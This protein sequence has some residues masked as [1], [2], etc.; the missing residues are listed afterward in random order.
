MGDLVRR[1]G[2]KYIPH[3]RHNSH[4]SLNSVRSLPYN[5]PLAIYTKYHLI[6][7]IEEQLAMGKG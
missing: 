7:Q 6:C 5:P 3:L 2:M 4:I 1:V